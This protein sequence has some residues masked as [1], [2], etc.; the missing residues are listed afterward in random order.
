MNPGLFLLAQQGSPGGSGAWMSLLPMVAI[1]AIF[2]F[3]LIWPMRKR[4]KALQKL[5][6]NLK[7][8]DKVLTNGGLYGEVAAV[9]GQVLHL[10]IADNVK[11]KIARSSVAGLEGDGETEGRK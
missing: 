1:F 8:G 3:V 7:R 11:V 2:Y 9:D 6:E 4:Q 5:I 10:K